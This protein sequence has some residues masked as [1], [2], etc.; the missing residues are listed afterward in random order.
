MAAV[1]CCNRRVMILKATELYCVVG[2]FCAR[3]L[4][5]VVTTTDRSVIRLCGRSAIEIGGSL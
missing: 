5:R 2:P 3:V 1:T 4:C